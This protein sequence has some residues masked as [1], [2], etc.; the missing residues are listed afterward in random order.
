MPLRSRPHSAARHRLE[1][2]CEASRVIVVL[3]LV[4]VVVV[5]VVEVRY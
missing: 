3:A 2:F 5:L 4:L 1:L